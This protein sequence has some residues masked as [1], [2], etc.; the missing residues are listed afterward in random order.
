MRSFISEVV[1]T[2]VQQGLTINYKLASEDFYPAQHDFHKV[3]VHVDYPGGWTT[4]N[5]IRIKATDT[6]NQSLEH[7]AFVDNIYYDRTLNGIIDLVGYNSSF[8]YPGEKELRLTN[9]FSTNPTLTIQSGSTLNL[10]DH[11][12]KAA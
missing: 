1:G 3:K 8:S 7:R 6:Q 2:T 4:V 5:E 9:A 10:I 12:P 11:P